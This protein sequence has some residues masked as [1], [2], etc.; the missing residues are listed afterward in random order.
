VYV[1]C[2]NVPGMYR[3]LFLVWLH[4][5]RLAIEIIGEPRWSSHRK[6][7][8]PV[9]HRCFRR[10]NNFGHTAFSRIF[11]YHLVI[12]A[13]RNFGLGLLWMVGEFR[14]PGQF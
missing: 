3:E 8:R 12:L 4:T 10:T 2:P 6:L 7:D 5:T 9:K 13:L 11:F 14:E 1:R